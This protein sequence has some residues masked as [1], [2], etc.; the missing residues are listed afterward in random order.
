MVF[1]PQFLNV[2]LEFRAQWTVIPKAIDAAVNLGGLKNEPPTLAH[3]HNFFH[4]QIFFPVRAIGLLP[5]ISQ[6]H[7]EINP[8]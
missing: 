6:K 4:L 5:V 1:P 8:L 3:R 2:A 7:R